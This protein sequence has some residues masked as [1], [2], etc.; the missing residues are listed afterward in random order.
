MR[1]RLPPLLLLALGSVILTKADE[2]A[3]E[4]AALCASC[5]GPAL[6]GGKGPS[7]LG[8]LHHGDEAPDLARSITV[9]FP[10]TGMP[11]I[12]N[13]LAPANVT[14]LVVYLREQRSQRVVPCP[15]A[16]LDQQLIRHSQRHDYR[17]EAI[18][19]D[20]LQI[21]WSFDWLPDGRILLTERAG[22]LRVIKDG[23]LL[24]APIAGVPEVIERGEG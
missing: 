19:E 21:P 10:A 2:P 20:G 12:G 8:T 15:A 24:S 9:G 17:I 16:H 3:A 23:K 7:L 13:A 14:A 6:E 22:R 11:A 18:V 4:Y 5:H 1:F